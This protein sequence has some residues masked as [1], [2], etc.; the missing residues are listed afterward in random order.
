MFQLT[1]ESQYTKIIYT[2]SNAVH[3][4]NQSIVQK[5]DKINTVI[6]NNNS[7]N[8]A[9]IKVQN[10]KDKFID[11]LIYLSYSDVVV[12]FPS[13]NRKLAKEKIK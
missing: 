2:D 1:T 6:I 13:S 10:D 12:K 5:L 11:S 7:N 9:S 4:I 3:K 8:A